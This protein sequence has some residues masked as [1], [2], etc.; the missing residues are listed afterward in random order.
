MPA[1]PRRT[2]PGKLIVISA[3]SGSGKTTIAREMIRL[4]P[5]LRFSVSATTR[6][7]RE[8][9]REGE[10]YYFLTRE[11]F[12][13][14]VDRGEFVEWE[15]LFGNYYGTLKSELDNALTNGRHLLFDVDVKGG[16]SIKK[17]YPSALMIFIRTP[18]EEILRDRLLNR[19]T[20]TTEVLA[21]R[22][23]RVSMELEMGSAYEHQ[24][25]N[26]DLPTA[27][28]EVDTIIRKYLQ[29]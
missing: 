7:K 28:R 4:H 21:M 12:R 5:S 27:V 16:I 25:V 10:D 6:Q 2:G 29:T 3:P 23:K 24:I 15:E 17:V 8:G 22:L 9:E 1:E 11:E 13:S 20:E 18:N 26:D 19:R 14:R